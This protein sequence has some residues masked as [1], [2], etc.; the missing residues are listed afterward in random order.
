MLM[1]DEIEPI[2]PILKITRLSQW[3]GWCVTPKA[4]FFVLNL[5]KCHTPYEK[6]RASCVSTKIMMLNPKCLMK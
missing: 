3:E 5:S 6:T 1:R 2:Y 4:L